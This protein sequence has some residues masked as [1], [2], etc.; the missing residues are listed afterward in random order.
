MDGDALRLLIGI[1]ARNAE[2]TLASVLDRI[3]RDFVRSESM[4]VLVV[5]DASPDGTF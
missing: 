2:T 4:H 1:S 3:P 5:D